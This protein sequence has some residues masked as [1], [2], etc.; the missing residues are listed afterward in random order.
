LKVHV[1]Y[2]NADGFINKRSELSLLLNNVDEK[3]HIIA[4]TE[5]KPK[6]TKYP[7]LA[8]EL[9]I[10]GYNHFS[11]Y[12]EGPKGRGIVIYVDCRL[13]ATQLEI[14][15]NF[16]ENLLLEITNVKKNINLLFGAIYRSPNSTAQN[17]LELNE[18]IKYV[19]KKHTGS[20]I[21]VGDFNYSQINWS[22]WAVYD[23]A[24][25]SD[26]AKKFLSCLRKH[27][28]FQHVSEPT[29]FRAQHEPHVL[30]LVITD[31]DFIDSLEYCSPLGKSDHAILSFVC[32]FSPEM[33]PLEPRL[34][35]NKGNYNGLRE[36]L[37]E[38]WDREFPDKDTVDE[39]WSEFREILDDG[40]RRHIPFT[41]PWKKN[42]KW[43]YPIDT[44]YKKN[45]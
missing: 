2:T 43:H 34:N 4:I 28:M 40:I 44:E 45:D 11:A 1:W 33:L 14:P 31:E 17:D 30:D 41:K 32:N 7:L 13:K 35:L 24:S 18:V 19:N 6:N 25:N 23:S 20:K 9:S 10:S 16:Q 12:I 36:F 42:S 29:R 27:F 39:M 3:P 21:F 22:N 38:E 26:S 5:V 15:V 8:S 37:A